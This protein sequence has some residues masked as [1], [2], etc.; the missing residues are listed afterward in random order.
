MMKFKPMDDC[1]VHGVWVRE[2]PEIGL[3]P[4]VSFMDG[5]KNGIFLDGFQKDRVTIFEGG[6]ST[7]SF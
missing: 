1:E 4:V 7:S 5:Q 2:I 3:P 6:G